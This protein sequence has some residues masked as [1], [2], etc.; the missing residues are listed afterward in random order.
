MRELVGGWVVESRKDGVVKLAGK[1]VCKAVSAQ[2]KL[3]GNHVRARITERVCTQ[4]SDGTDPALL[5][6]AG[7]RFGRLLVLADVGG[8]RFK[9]RC[10]C[11]QMVEKFASRLLSITSHECSRQCV[12]RPPRIRRS[13]ARAKAPKLAGNT[14]AAPPP[15]ATAVEKLLKEVEACL[16]R[17]GITEQQFAAE[18]GVARQLFWRLRNGRATTWRSY[19]KVAG[20][21]R[22]E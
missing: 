21:A 7:S 6:L 5:D 15:T 3:A 20:H 12:L 2:A 19:K 9:C 1:P 16:R 8:G 22:K 18:A 4:I 13:R 10:D 14:A 17:R 11:G